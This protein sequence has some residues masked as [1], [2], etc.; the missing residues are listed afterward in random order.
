[1]THG[2]NTTR[3]GPVQN[4]TSQESNGAYEERKSRGLLIAEYRS[5]QSYAIKWCDNVRHIS[6]FME[7]L[8]REEMVPADWE[9]NDIVPTNKQKDDPLK[10]G[11]YRGI[12][13]WKI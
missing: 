12:R 8:W 5:Q 11:N 9:K 10:C 7:S 1:M 13:C 3:A 6:E 2:V 4:I